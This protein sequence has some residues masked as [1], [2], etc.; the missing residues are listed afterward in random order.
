MITACELE[1]ARRPRSGTPDPRRGHRVIRPRRIIERWGLDPESLPSEES[2]HAS[3][4]ELF[5][6]LV[7][8]LAL[9]AV[10]NRLTDEVPDADEILRTAGL[11]VIVWWAWVGQAF[12]DTR[13]DPDDLGHR[14]AVLV[15]MVGAGI[16]A[17][18]AKDA[19]HTLLLPIGYLVVRGT[20][21]ALYLRVR[22]TGTTA[23]RLTTVYFTGF[24][25]GL[26]FWV[27]SL[28]VPPRYRPWL[29]LIGLV[30][31]LLTPWLGRRWLIQHPVHPSHLPERIGQFT[32]I[33]LGVSLTDLIAA[34]PTRPS[35][36]VAA[37]AITAF[38]I[39]ASVWWV[40]TTFVTMGLTTSRLSAGLGYAT[41]HGAIGSALLLLG[42]C[43]GQA[44]REVGAGHEDLP[45]M[46]RLLLAVSLASWMVG[47]LAL[48]RIALGTIPPV[49]VAI[50]VVSIGLVGTVSLVPPPIALMPLIALVMIAY[51]VVVSRLIVRFG[52]E[53]IET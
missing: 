25:A 45:H 44:V 12:Y 7:F 2:R 48:Q 13:F 27:A 30:V 5:F 15:G 38:L 21:L 51:A 49:R 17:V 4:L 47:G 53:R 1:A 8:V 3:W 10:Q 23:R 26:A 42:W 18:G 22:G 19:P 32:I 43:L 34:V 52:K 36:A 40:Y 16:M 41:V 46:L 37:V 24:S 20:L 35:P 14:L 28:A 9:A 39:P 6:D 33:L 11:Y 31:E 50:A 29:W